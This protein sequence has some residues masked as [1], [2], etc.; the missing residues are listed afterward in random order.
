MS[1]VQLGMESVK[2]TDAEQE[3]SC[4]PSPCLFSVC[5]RQLPAR[6]KND[7]GKLVALVIL[8]TQDS[9]VYLLK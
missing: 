8:V 9:S 6:T 7:R 4:F 2:T 3:G 1:P 5:V